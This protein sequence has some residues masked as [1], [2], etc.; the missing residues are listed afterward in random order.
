[1]ELEIE[2]SKV[3]GAIII[4][5]LVEDDKTPFSFYHRETFMGYTVAQAKKIFKQHLAEN[6]MWLVGGGRDGLYFRVVK[7]ED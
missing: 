2:K 7:Q 6:K 4:T 3:S 5:A 1:M